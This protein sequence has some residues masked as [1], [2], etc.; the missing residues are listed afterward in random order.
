MR[1]LAFC[2]LILSLLTTV[3]RAAAGTAPAGARFSPF[4]P[5]N[6]AVAVAVDPGSGVLYAGFELGGL[7]RSADGG[8]SWAWSGKGLGHRRIKAVTVGLAGEIYAVAESR[9]SFEIVGSFDRGASWALLSTL[10]RPEGVSV[11]PGALVPGGEPGSLYLAL[12]RELWKSEDRGRR[13]SRVLQ[14]RSGLNAVAAGRRGSREVYVGTAEP[15]ARVLRS[16]DGGSTWRELRNGLPAGAVTGLALSP[17]AAGQ[18]AKIYAGI[19]RSG[20]FASR[21]GGETW[22]QPDF[23]YGTLELSDVALDGADPATLYAAYRVGREEPFRVRISRDG[24]ATWRSGGLLM[25]ESPP[26]YGIALI[27]AR[28]ALYALGDVDL[29]ASIDG[30]GTWSYR[31]RGGT[32]PGGG[33]Q[34]RCA[35]GDPS[36]MYA[37]IGTRAFKSMDGGRTW[38]SFATSLLRH[39]KIALR[40]L[41]VDPAHPATLY[42]AGDLGV[43]RS[44]DSG[45]RWR[46]WGP[47][48]RRL[49]LLPGGT[50]LAGDCGLMRTT[51]GGATWIEVLSCRVPDG[52][53][54]KIEKILP[55]LATPGTVFLAVTEDTP[56]PVVRQIYRSQDSGRT[57]M[58]IVAGASVL[59]LSPRPPAVLYVVKGDALLASRDGGETFRRVG[60]HRLP[61]LPRTEPIADLLVDRTAP[62]TL[63]AATRGFGLR[64][65]TDGGATWA[66]LRAEGAPG[67]LFS[68]FADPSRPDVLYAATGGALVR[69]EL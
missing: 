50:I 1:C 23:P 63:Y 19:G 25:A 55:D 65:S 16:A 47:A 46:L 58:P 59:A 41:V 52:G 40:D 31:L 64:R 20:L 18:P 60:P 66:E 32:G 43:F 53:Q 37:L 15:G 51:D 56:P 62:T 11:R 38:S 8:R 54:R 17:G 42:A 29:A 21:D 36:T 6:G 61:P 26:L 28:D 13:W 35:P 44:S 7:F 24:G 9:P 10:P 39:G 67:H 14:A 27:A 33:S 69:V 2:L 48:A 22:W 45:R 57:W 49:A 34:V 30:G 68:L 12:A 4:G 5:G 3:Q